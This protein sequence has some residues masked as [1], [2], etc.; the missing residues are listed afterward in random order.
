MTFASIMVCVDFDEPSK[1]RIGV[2]A[3]LATRFN[4]VLIG[5]AG[6]P[7]RKSGM[8]VRSEVDFP[9]VEESLQAKIAEELER[10][11]QMFRCRAG[12]TPRGVEWRSS[13]H[14]PNEVIANEARAA[15]LVILGRDPLHDDAYHTFDPGAVI[16]ALRP[17]GARA[18]VWDQ[19]SA[20]F[21]CPDCLERFARGAT[22]S[23][24]RATIPERGGKRRYRGDRA[25]RSGDA[26]ARTDRRSR[27]LPWASW[28]CYRRKNC[29]VCP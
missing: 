24:R 13:A 7:L 4:A 2:A 25:T 9:P 5:V 17:A 26:I 12:A 19:S 1:E 21:A 27:K 22:G 8:P 18:A 3:E 15:D 10:L 20:D 16:L 29:G 14:F 6:W 11:G 28:G 23:T